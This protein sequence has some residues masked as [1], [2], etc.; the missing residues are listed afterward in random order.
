LIRF[1]KCGHFQNENTTH[2]YQDTTTKWFF[3][4]ASAICEI[5][6]FRM[7]QWFGERLESPEKKLKIFIPIQG[8]FVTLQV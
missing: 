1:P 5:P 4:S 3:V 2:I 8:T 6:I 7:T